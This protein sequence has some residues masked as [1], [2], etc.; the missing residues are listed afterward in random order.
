MQLRCACDRRTCNL[1]RL[2]V[3]CPAEC[4]LLSVPSCYHCALSSPRPLPS[5]LTP[6]A[7]PAEW[8]DRHTTTHL[9]ARC[10]HARPHV[11]DNLSSP[12]LPAPLG[13]S[14]PA[15]YQVLGTRARWAGTAGGPRLARAGFAGRW[16]G[17]AGGACLGTA[18]RAL[19]IRVIEPASDL[20]HRNPLIEA[21]EV[22]ERK[23][24]KLRNRQCW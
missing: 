2:V 20:L 9:P 14:H 19:T 18:A 15:S 13:A 5:T 4:A 24:E 1:D 3:G 21:R 12:R 16:A 6:L 11:G 8:W 22:G 23:V 7:C 10:Q 17:T